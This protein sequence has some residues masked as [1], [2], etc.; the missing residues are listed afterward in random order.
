[1]PAPLYLPLRGAD[2]VVRANTR[3]E[4]FHT[5]PFRFNEL[6]TRSDRAIELPRIMYITE[7]GDVKGHDNLDT[8]VQIVVYLDIL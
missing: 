2:I 6:I 4:I 3:N 8:I 1:M 7:I 5:S